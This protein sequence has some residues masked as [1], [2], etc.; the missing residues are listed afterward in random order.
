MK[1]FGIR[2][3]LVC[4][5]LLCGIVVSGCGDSQAR[6]DAAS[7][8]MIAAHSNLV[9]ALDAVSDIGTKGGPDYKESASAIKDARTKL[10][11]VRLDL[12]KAAAALQG[13]SGEDGDAARKDLEVLKGTA[14]KLE[15]ALA[16]GELTVITG[17]AVDQ[18]IDGTDKLM[19]AISA[20]NKENYTKAESLGRKAASKFSQAIGTLNTVSLQ[21]PDADLS[22]W[23]KYCKQ[24]R[25]L[26]DME[27]KMDGYGRTKQFDNYNRMV[28]AYNKNKNALGKM[29]DPGEVWTD[30]NDRWF[31]AQE[32]IFEQLKAV[33]EGPGAS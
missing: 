6:L 27:V 5:L 16:D 17:G 26:A 3:A 13:V 8:A 30:I 31:K 25:T 21:Y 33:G 19:S 7:D 32:D 9:D 18:M 14:D 1:R 11:K 24:A 22:A 28:K 2:L 20:S 23:T 4:A 15:A 10:D 12:D 29:K